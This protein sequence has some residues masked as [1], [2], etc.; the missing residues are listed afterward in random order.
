MRAFL[1]ASALLVS[2]C[3]E[4]EPPPNRALVQLQA[5]CDAGN[6]AACDSVLEHQRGVRANQVMGAALIPPPTYTP[7]TFPMMR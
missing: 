1:I 2:A 4:S 7:M 3:V 5:A 6:L